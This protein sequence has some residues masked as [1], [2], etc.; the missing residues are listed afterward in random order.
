[1]RVLILGP[2]HAGGSLPPY[3]DVLAAGL[4][5]HGV[6]VDRHGS[7]QIPYDHARHR[8]WPL[9][10]VLTEARALAEQVDLDGYDLVSL[11]CGNL[12]IDQLIPALWAN[13]RTG[14]TAPPVVSHVHTLAPT[15]L[16]DHVPDRHWNH[17]VQQA[18]RAVDGYVFFGRYARHRL[19]GTLRDGVPAGVAWLPTTIPPDT[20]PAARPALAAALDTPPGAPVISLYGYAAPWK[21]AALLHAA[22]QRMR[23]PARIVLAGD[24]W[25]QPE[26]AGLDLTAFT[27]GPVRVGTGELVVVPGYLGSA[28]RAALVRASAAGVFPYRPHPSFQGSGAIAD[29][30]AHAVPVVATDVANMAELAGAAGRTVSTGDPEILATALDSIARGGPAAANHVCN[31]GSRAHQFTAATHAARCLA[32]YQQVLDHDRRRT[33]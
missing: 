18:L 29:Y 2:D 32:I 9:E 33:A 11:H 5:H 30:L 26:Q 4:R 1:M 19:A 15:L 27:A 22:L 17:V 6:T 7:S 21:D 14:R 23:V 25:D 13:Q 31:A 16:R 3:L 24:F 28:D 10:R 20:V 8:F 12:E